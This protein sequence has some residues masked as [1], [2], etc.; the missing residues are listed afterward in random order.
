VNLPLKLL[1]P[2]FLSVEEALTLQELAIDQYGGTHGLREPGLLDSALAMPRQSFG[3]EFAHSFPFGMAAAYAFHLSGNHTFIDGN[4]RIGFACAVTFLWMNGWELT[5]T[6]DQA[7]AMMLNVAKGE[8]QKQ[9]IADWFQQHSRPRVSFEL[10]DFLSS[11]DGRS[12]LDALQAT[13]A[14]DRP[15]EFDASL[16]EAAAAIPLLHDLRE[17]ARQFVQAAD[18]VG[19][20]RNA[21]QI[22]LL[23]HLYRIAEDMG[24]EW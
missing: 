5:A 16:D 2:R 22:A 20:G 10:R 3:G 11:V 13:A 21:A 12:F 6:E 17:Q 4:K 1:Q 24:Y 19:L 18:H 23:M 15:H 7:T 9:A 14:A 8:L